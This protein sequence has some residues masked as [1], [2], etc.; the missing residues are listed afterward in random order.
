M[1]WQPRC[2][3]LQA[4]LNTACLFVSNC[5]VSFMKH[6]VKLLPSVICKGNIGFFKISFTTIHFSYNLP[7]CI[8]EPNPDWHIGS[9]QKL[10]KMHD[11]EWQSLFSNAYRR[12]MT[13]PLV[14]KLTFESLKIKFFACHFTLTPT[15]RTDVA[16]D[17]IFGSKQKKE[18]QTQCN[19]AVFCQQYRSKSLTSALIGLHLFCVL[20]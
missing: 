1:Y 18:Y 16:E 17:P 12:Y 19:F 10:N 2:D 20:S 6:V 14:K 4:W 15:F 8:S 5:G 3:W 11:D 9:G 7:A 13:S